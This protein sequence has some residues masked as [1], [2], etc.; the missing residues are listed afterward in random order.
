LDIGLKKVVASFSPSL[1]LVFNIFLFGPYTIYQGNIDEFALPLKSIL[2]FFLIPALILFS[3]LSAIGLLL[4]K[5]AHQRYISIIFILGVLI[6]LQG[7]I[8]VWK[9]GLLNG[10]GID[11]SKK[12]WRGWVD[13]TLWIVLLI[14]AYLFCRQIYKTASFASILLISLLLVS[15]LFTGIQKPEIWK[16]K[17]KFSLP[18]VPPD[19]IFEFSSKQN[20]IH[21]ILDGFQSDIFQEI[22]SENI[23]H[24][25]TSLEGFTFFKETIGCFPTTYMS[26]PAFLSG[27]IYK[28]KIPMRKFVDGVIQGRTITNVLHDRG[29]E[30]DCVADLLF[31]KKAR[32][33]YQYKI[34]IPYGGSKQKYVKANSALMLDLVL[35][36]YAPHLLKKAIYNNQLW[37]IQRALAPK[38]GNLRLRYFSHQAFLKEMIDQISVNT[39]KPVYKYIHLMT[40]HPPVVVNNKCEYAKNILGTRENL[41]IQ[42]KCS[43]DHFIEFLNMLKSKGIY[44]SSLII[45]QAD[46]GVG[47]EVRMKNIDK[48]LKEDFFND[49]NRL[50]G[51]AGSALALLAVKPPYSKGPLKI[52]SAQVSL[53]DIPATISSLLNINEKFNGRSVFEID[54]NDVRERK[55]YYHEWR[56]ENWKSDYFDRLDEFIIEGSVFDRASW[57]LG[58]VYYSPKRSDKRK[59]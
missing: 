10:Q 15:L 39:M 21:F 37:L 12:L 41:K 33:S 38:N 31:S 25:S 58:S 35:F 18:S 2:N 16:T 43:L 13:G 27:Q 51:I 52:S 34:A 6:W 47:K 29:Y 22:I 9:Y 30:V 53:T 36:R 7:N 56:H 24:Y 44:E 23:N 55:F 32:Y 5:K 54:P 1:F 45:L 19:E 46:H 49:K 28:N 26:V 42:D 48:K 14:M 57:R 59:R 20:I 3:V 50:A 17:E 40:S 8:L 4:P 11:W